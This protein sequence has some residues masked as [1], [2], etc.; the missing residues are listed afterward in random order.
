MAAYTEL[1]ID[2]GAD[3]ESALDLIADD[4]TAINVTGYIF[5]AQMRKSYYSTNPSAT[6]TIQILDAANGNAV[7]T[8]NSATT[9][10]IAGGRYLYDVKMADPASNTVTRI[11]EGIVTVTPQITK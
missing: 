1:F 9:T 10:N 6:F 4:G 5:S 11:V 2:Q 8:M 3:F 7:I